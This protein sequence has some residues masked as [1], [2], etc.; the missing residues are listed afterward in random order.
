MANEPTLSELTNI[1]PEATVNPGVIVDHR[2]AVSQLNQSAQFNADMHQRKYELGLKNLAALYQDI[3]NVADTPIMQQDRPIVFGRLS[4]ILSTIAED[5]RAALGGPKFTE[6]QR[7]LGQVRM[8]ATNSKQD[9][10]YS[11][12]NE[13]WLKQNPDVDTPQNR[14]KLATFD[15]SALGARKQFMLDTPVKFDPE[16][17]MGN[18]LKQRQVAVPYANTSFE[19]PNNEWMIRETG[20][21][22]GRDSALKMWDQGY[23]TGTDANNQPI[24]KWAGEQFEKLKSDPAQMERFGNPENPQQLYENIGRMMFGASGDIIGEKTS[25]RTANPY[26]M[27]GLRQQ[28]ALYME[29]IK[30]GNRE[31]LAA[32][33]ANL[34]LQGAP[35]NANFLVRQYA[36]VV[37]NL[38]GQSNT[39]ETSRGKFEKEEVVDVPSNILKVYANDQKT[40]LKEGH[41]LDPITETIIQGNQADLVTRTKD[42]NLRLSFYKH[43]NK[44]DRVPKGK[45]VGDLVTDNNGNPILETSGIIPRRNLLTAIGK[46][47]VETKLLSS[48]IDQADKALQNQTNTVIDRVNSGEDDGTVIQQAQ[49]QTHST[50]TYSYK[51]KTYTHAQIETAAKQSGMTADQYIKQLGLK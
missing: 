51:G 9:K 8:M 50:K 14:E 21:T 15:G 26:T 23:A 28:N 25:T 35:E 12:F 30:E 47:V 42:G 40:T 36:N 17:A 32:I 43:Y 29:A 34:R 18:I 27:L 5:P 44:S 33:R 6:I 31:K 2:E 16:V 38:T 3:G 22:Y 10:V 24:K 41:S 49:Q 39:V 4:K 37:G 19:G 13:K 20:T 1:R 46:G 11:D 48:A 7:D 45:H